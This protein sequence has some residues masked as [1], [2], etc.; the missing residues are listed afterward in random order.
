MKEEILRRQDIF[1]GFVEKELWDLT[2]NYNENTKE[3]DIMAHRDNIMTIYK[4]DI[5]FLEQAFIKEMIGKLPRE[6]W[7]DEDH[8]VGGYISKKDLYNLL[9]NPLPSNKGGD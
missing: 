6:F 1:K 8:A 5:V 2:S 9:T 7:E 3:S 4:A